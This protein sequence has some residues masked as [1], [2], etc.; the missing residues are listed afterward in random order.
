MSRLLL[1]TR[2]EP[3]LSVCW[4][5]RL[6]RCTVLLPLIHHRRCVGDLLTEEIKILTLK[7]NLP[8]K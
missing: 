5:E 1:P 8:N 7:G 3:G 2:P 4:A 6:P